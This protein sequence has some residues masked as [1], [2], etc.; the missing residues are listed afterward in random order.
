[1]FN[2]KQCLLWSHN[3]QICKCFFSNFLMS[4]VINQLSLI[5]VFIIL[6]I[7]TLVSK[8]HHD[9]FISSKDIVSFANSHFSTYLFIEMIQNFVEII[10][11]S[12]NN[13]KQSLWSGWTKFFDW[14]V[15]QNLTPR[16]F[17]WVTRKEFFLLKVV[18]N[19]KFII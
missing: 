9:I 6:W 15:P 8:N 12:T 5:V 13:V 3:K 10:I 1:L 14:E 4:V 7:V 2:V 11:M 19:E 18:G 16:T 17:F